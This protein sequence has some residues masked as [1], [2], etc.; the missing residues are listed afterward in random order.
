MQMVGDKMKRI[1]VR[2][3]KWLRRIFHRPIVKTIP[4][5][6]QHRQRIK[7]SKNR[8]MIVRAGSSMRRGRLRG[9]R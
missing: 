7:V 9:V 6:L 4:F 3:L 8:S 2:L 5:Q 1:F